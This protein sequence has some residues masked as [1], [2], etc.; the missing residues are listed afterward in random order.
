LTTP[1]SVGSAIE[2]V[3]RARLNLRPGSIK[4]HSHGTIASSPNQ[5]SG[6]FGEIFRGKGSIIWTGVPP[7]KVELDKDG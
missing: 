6:P 4:N 2:H 3:W 5:C 1:T 7:V